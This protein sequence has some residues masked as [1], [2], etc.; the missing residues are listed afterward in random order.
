MNF[1]KELKSKI[2]TLLDSIESTL[3]EKKIPIYGLLYYYRDFL[4]IPRR[5]LR[6]ANMEGAHEYWDDYI[7]IYG[8]ATQENGIWQ[9][10]YTIDSAINKDMFPLVNPIDL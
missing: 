8:N 5:S 4:P 9:T 2:D 10:P 3:H 6:I 7:D 1:K